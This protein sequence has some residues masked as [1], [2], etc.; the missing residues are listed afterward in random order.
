MIYLSLRTS[1][2]SSLLSGLLLLHVLKAIS[3]V[4]QLHLLA[5]E[6]PPRRA[7]VLVG[8]DFPEWHATKIIKITDPRRRPSQG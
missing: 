1:S 8:V 7:Y 2:P 4:V 6:R 3:G 5:R